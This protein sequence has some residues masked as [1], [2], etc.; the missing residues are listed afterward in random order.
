MHL[1][2]KIIIWIVEKKTKSLQD[3]LINVIAETPPA[4]P[5]RFAPK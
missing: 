4:A 5:V 3:E 1:K 2:T